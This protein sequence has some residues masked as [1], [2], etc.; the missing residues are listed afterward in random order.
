MKLIVQS[1]TTMVVSLHAVEFALKFA[2]R[3]IGIGDGK[4]QFDLPTQKVTQ[5]I[6]SNL[7]RSEKTP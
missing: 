7:Y 5:T 3:I 1:A 2:S 6:L 4:L